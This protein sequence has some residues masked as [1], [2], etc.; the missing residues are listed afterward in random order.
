MVR[1]LLTGQ[2][3]DQLASHF[4]DH[5]RAH[6][7]AAPTKEQEAK[8]LEFY[9][10]T[11]PQLNEWRKKMPPQTFYVW[12]TASDEIAKCKTSTMVSAPKFILADYNSIIQ[13]SRKISPTTKVG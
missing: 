7:Y 6:A 11:L 10:L 4:T 5:F 1:P 9:K 3:G 13:Y 12:Q 2:F 8:A